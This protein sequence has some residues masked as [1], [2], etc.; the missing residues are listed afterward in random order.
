MRFQNGKYSSEHRNSIQN[1]NKTLPSLPL[2]INESIP[3]EKSTE[4]DSSLP[5]FIH[6]Q[7]LTDTLSSNIH[8]G[9]T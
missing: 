4:E 7:S 5:I 9:N 6:Q 2:N 8:T 3:S 1:D